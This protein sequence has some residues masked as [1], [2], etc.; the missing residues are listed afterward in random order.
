MKIDLKGKWI[1]QFG[2]IVEA[3][4]IETKEG[5]CVNI[6]SNNKKRCIRAE[7]KTLKFLLENYI[8]LE[9]NKYVLL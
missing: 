6:I 4:P 9:E 7:V 1:N 3:E 5:M 2:R 8:R